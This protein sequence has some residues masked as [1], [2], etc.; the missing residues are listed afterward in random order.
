[1][2]ILQSHI[3]IVAAAI[4]MYEVFRNP[5]MKSQILLVYACRM[6]AFERKLVHF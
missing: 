3:A 6:T 1:M 2:D 4:L 5:N